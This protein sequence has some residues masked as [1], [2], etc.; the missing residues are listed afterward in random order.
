MA[1]DNE[2]SRDENRKTSFFTIYDTFFSVVTDDMYMELT[3]EDT[4]QMLQSILLTSL[5]RFEFPRFDIFDYEEGAWDYLGDYV[6]VES[7]G[8]EVAAYGW[9]G[10]FFNTE[11]TLEE[12]NIIAFNMVV[13]WLQQQLDTTENSKQIYTGSDFKMTSQANHMAKLKVL[14]DS[15][16]TDSLHLQRLYKRRIRKPN[17]EI[18]STLGSLMTKPHYGFKI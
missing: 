11:L 8:K 16:K 9:V 5:P 13:G 1:K 10:G 15:H 17:G 7:D 4:Y 3:E 2:M 18:Q 14:I 12:I 6:G